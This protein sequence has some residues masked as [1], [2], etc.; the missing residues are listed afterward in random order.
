M[1]S[2]KLK[3]NKSGFCT[4]CSGKKEDHYVVKNQLPTWRDSDGKIRFDIPEELSNLTLAEKMLI[5]RVS[6]LVPLQ[7]IKNGTF[8]LSG[9][10]C[11]F[12]QEITE[13]A[14]VLP[15]AVSDATVIQVFKLIKAEITSRQDPGSIKCFRVRPTRVLRALEFLKRFSS[16][17]ED[18]VIDKTRLDWIKNGEGDLNMLNLVV[19]VAEMPVRGKRSLQDRN[20]DQGPSKKQCVD[21]EAE[22]TLVKDF[23]SLTDSGVGKLNEE[24]TIINQELQEAVAKSGLDHGGI[25][26]PTISSLPVNE[27]STTKIFAR[28]FP[29]LYPG[30]VGD[31]KDHE[32]PERVLNDWG[33]MMLYHRDGRFATDKLFTFFCLNYIVRHRNAT[34]GGFFMEKFIKN[35]PSDLESLK[36]QLASGNTSFLRNLSYY[37]KRIK[38][39]TSYWFQKRSEVFAWI[40]QHVSMGNGAPT[41][42]ITLSCAEYFWPDVVDLLRDRLVIAGL[43]PDDCKIGSPSFIQMCN[44]FSIVIQEYFQMRTEAWLETV[45]KKLFGIKHYWVRYEFAPGRGQIHAHLLAISDDQTIH[46]ECYNDLKETN[47]HLLRENRLARW[48]SENLGLTAWT[49]PGFGDHEIGDDNNPVKI[50]FSDVDQNELARRIDGQ[51]LLQFCQVHECSGFCMKQ[52]HKSS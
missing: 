49:D 4:K 16:E 26:W 36:Q 33:K 43:D 30:G 50:R 37:N 6:P 40:N 23:G 47:G 10:V 45:G 52:N 25:N 39:S 5:Q 41:Y 24:D 29:W 11:A 17:Y 51:R 32:K 2:L 27:Y 35:P 13:M 34:S 1:V 46:S 28:A 12:E 9:H 20:L 8:G 22:A 7:H 38:G 14:T 18:I 3:V 19:D 21:P 48:A 15:R 42:F 31:I 44:D